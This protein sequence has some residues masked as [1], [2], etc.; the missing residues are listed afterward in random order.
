MNSLCLLLRETTLGPVA[1]TA[2]ASELMTIF[3]GVA[4]A[5]KDVTNGDRSLP[6][7]F[8][9]GLRAEDA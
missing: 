5:D 8:D 6:H 2:Q 3:Q 1:G 7:F 9:T 4:A